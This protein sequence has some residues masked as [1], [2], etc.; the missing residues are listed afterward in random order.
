V[1]LCE[2]SEGVIGV[3]FEPEAQLKKEGFLA[4]FPS[5]FCCWGNESGSGG[6]GVSGRCG[7]GRERVE[8]TRD[9]CWGT[10]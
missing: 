7:S 10:A 9:A 1:G 5:S 3:D 2:V 8:R 6:G 4:C